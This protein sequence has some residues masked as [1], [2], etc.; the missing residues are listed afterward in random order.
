MRGEG[1]KKRLSEEAAKMCHPCDKK[2]YPPANDGGTCNLFFNKV[3]EQNKRAKKGGCE[4]AVISGP[5]GARVWHEI[6]GWFVKLD[7]GQWVFEG[8]EPF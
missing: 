5:D 1:L 7:N 4:R 2:G 8:K 6:Y 3:E